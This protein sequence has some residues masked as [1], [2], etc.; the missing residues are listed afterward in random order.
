MTI[1]PLHG[2][3]FA[4]TDPNLPGP[5][6]QPLF[7][8]VPYYTPEQE[9]PPNGFSLC[10]GG[11][12]PTS[13]GQISLTG[14]GVDDPLAIDPN[15][16]A[17]DYDVNTL[18]TSL[19]MMREI[20]NQP[21]LKE[22]RGREIFPGEDVKTDA[23]LADYCRSAVVS[24]HHQVGTCAMGKGDMA[25]VDAKLKVH[26]IDGLRV[27]DASIIPMVPSGNTNAPVIMIAEKAA[28]MIKA[29]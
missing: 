19:K 2:Q 20:A 12:M 1:T 6:M 29:G 9:G 26:G 3:L 10:A 8:N 11:V 28:D 24:Y 27:V 13:R 21:A 17:T 25:V 5:D 18:V 23:E 22:W 7:F 15:V 4:K 14:T 16:L